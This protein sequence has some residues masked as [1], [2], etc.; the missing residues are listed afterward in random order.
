VN[1]FPTLDQKLEA[2][3]RSLPDQQESQKFKIML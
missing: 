2:K 1:A 3:K